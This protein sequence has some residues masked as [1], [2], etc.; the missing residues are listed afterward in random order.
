MTIASARRALRRRRRRR[1]LVP[2]P[3]RV[4]CPAGD[5]PAVG[6]RREAGDAGGV[7]GQDGQAGVV[8]EGP[9]ADRAVA[10]A[11]AQPIRASTNA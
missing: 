7:P 1:H 10:G 11:C 3:E 6:E 9:H 5:D 2:D 4:V 8:R